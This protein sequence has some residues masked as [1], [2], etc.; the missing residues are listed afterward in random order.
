M[1][2]ITSILISK[3][4]K[5]INK[6]KIIMAENKSFVKYCVTWTERVVRGGFVDYI[7]YFINYEI[8]EQAN[9]KYEEVLQYGNLYAANLCKVIKT[10]E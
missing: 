6:H 8:L 4:K 1:N 7:D 3:F 9:L 10:T 5:D 2:Y